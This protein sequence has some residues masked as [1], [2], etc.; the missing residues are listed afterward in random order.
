MSNKLL[1]KMCQNSDSFTKEELVSQMSSELLE[2]DMFRSILDNLSEGH[3]VIDKEGDVYRLLERDV[4][5]CTRLQTPFSR[6]LLIQSTLL[7]LKNHSL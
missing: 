6:P 2:S 7:Y 1:K 3:I 4:Q 5:H